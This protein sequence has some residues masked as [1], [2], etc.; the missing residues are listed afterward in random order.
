MFRVRCR[1]KKFAY[2]V[3][4]PQMIEYLLSNR[5]LDIEIQGPAI[6]LAFLISNP[7]ETFSVC[8]HR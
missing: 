8:R 5:G 4:N 1:D 7:K 6:L 3:C 2:D